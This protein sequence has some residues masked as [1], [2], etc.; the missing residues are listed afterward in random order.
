MMGQYWLGKTIS[1]NK[2]SDQPQNTFKKVAM[3][4]K[5]FYFALTD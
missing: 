1:T 5:K 3:E 2:L 4:L